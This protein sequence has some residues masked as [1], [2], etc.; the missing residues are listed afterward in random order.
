MRVTTFALW[1]HSINRKMWASFSESWAIITA[2][3]GSLLKAFADMDPG[4]V[5]QNNR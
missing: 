2:G 1:P 3:L 4:D 5:A